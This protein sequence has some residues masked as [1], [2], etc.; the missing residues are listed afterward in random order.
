MS[1]AIAIKAADGQTVTLGDFRAA[2]AGAVTSWGDPI[3]VV[4][5]GI[6]LLNYR[7][8]EMDPMQMWKSQPSLRKVVGF[9]ARHY[10]AVP[11]HAH[12]RVGDNDRPRLANSP[13]EKILNAPAK[14]R[15]GYSFWET[16]MIDY[17]LYDRWCVMYWKAAREGERDSLVRIP[18]KLL[19]INS[20]AIG[21][22]TQ[23]IMTNPTPGED[24]VDLTNAPIAIGW[25][26]SD[27]AAGGT[28]PMQTLA[29]ILRENRL[30]V[31]W[32]QDQ[33]ENG[34]K[35]NGL[36]KHPGAFKANE[37][38]TRFLQDWADWKRNTG[39]T[40]L[41]E[42][43][44]EYQQLTS[45]SPK[46][47]RDIEGRTLTDIEVAGAYFIPPELV[48]SREG[49]FSNIARAGPRRRPEYLR[50]A[51]HQRVHPGQPARAG[52][53][54]LDPHRRPGPH[55]QRGEGHAQPA[56]RR[57]RR[58]A[59]RSPQRHPG[60][61]GQPPGLR[62]SEQDQRQP[63]RERDAPTMKPEIP[64]TKMFGAKAVAASEPDKR[65]QFEAYVSVFGNKDSQGDIVEAGAF[66]KSLAEWVVKGRPIPCVWS[67]QF[68]NPT[69]ILGEYKEAKE[70]DTGLRLV[71]QLETAWPEADRVYELML[72]QLVAEFSFSGKVRDYELMEVDKDDDDEDPWAW[73]FP[74]MK[75]KD[76]DLW[77]AGPCFKGANPETELLNVKS[78]E[79]MK[80][81][82]PLLLGKEGRVLASRHVD[83]LK[84]AR[85]Q[86]NDVIAEVEKNPD[87]E[88]GAGKAANPSVTLTGDAGPADNP[89]LTMRVRA[90]LEL[91]Q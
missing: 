19:R 16:A 66:T 68:H 60:R 12:R 28:S 14:F 59:D 24:D 10:A 79:R 81:L 27:G 70:T 11:W 34:P 82:R 23:V 2:G 77:E 1:G 62:R 36:L 67:H 61:P 25:G 5:P 38:R 20:N 72:K 31:E 78:E 6:P 52:P 80:A 74:G 41:L 43:G 58:P 64:I 90:L 51:E 56:R 42:N 85:D 4:D 7:P 47:A 89:H 30:A 29:A 21:V 17:L 44:M 8:G 22:V 86:L 83:A 18:P 45:V 75:I 13:A 53:A 87:P 3:R 57:G 65:G 40:P 54:A 71:G 50:R 69:S 37:N 76:I 15:S 39:G 84:S 33:W 32:R 48:G 9:A 91:S 46:D 63:G 55:H 26:W 35:I 73:L 49:N 88:Q